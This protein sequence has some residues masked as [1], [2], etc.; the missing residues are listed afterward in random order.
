M[1]VKLQYEAPVPPIYGVQITLNETEAH[2]LFVIASI[3]EDILRSALHEAS[4]RRRRM[5][6]H[7]VYGLRKDLEQALAPAALKRYL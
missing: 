4:Q 1:N 5:H 2:D 6:T 7:N 3:P